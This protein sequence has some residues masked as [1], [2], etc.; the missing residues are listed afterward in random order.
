MPVVS[1]VWYQKVVWEQVV[2]PDGKKIEVPC[3]LLAAIRVEEGD[4]AD[5]ARRRVRGGVGAEEVVHIAGWD[6]GGVGVKV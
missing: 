5:L 1:P 3:S 4:A 2:V 6:G